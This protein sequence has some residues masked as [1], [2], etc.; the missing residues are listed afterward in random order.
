LFLTLRDLFS[1]RV[2][3]VSYDLTSTYFEGEGPPNLGIIEREGI[4]PMR[5]N[6][7]LAASDAVRRAGPLG[8]F[9]KQCASAAAEPP[10]GC[11]PPTDRPGH[12]SRAS[13]DGLVAPGCPPAPHPLR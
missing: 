5:A 6:T 13:K 4:N 9:M 3:M 8:S 1:L 11:A 7:A 12:C 2:D 10:V